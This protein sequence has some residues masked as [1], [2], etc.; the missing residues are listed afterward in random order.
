MADD[1]IAGVKA[2]LTGTSTQIS[3]QVRSL[4]L[5]VLA[6]VWLFL[7]GGKDIPA[8]M[9]A[10]MPKEQLVAVAMLAIIALVVDLLQYVLGFV[11]SKAVLNSA[12]ASGSSPAFDTSA[13]LYRAR[14][15]AFWSK[16]AAAV[17]AVGWLLLLLG[18]A[19][20]A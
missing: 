17:A 4:V 10:A 6:F 3:S 2:D 18:K 15:F 9:V 1:P 13:L 8:S 20:F 14:T 12:E 19:V 5:G 16:Q 7:S 11:Y